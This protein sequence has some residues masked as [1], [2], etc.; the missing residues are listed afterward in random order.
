MK[1]KEKIELYR[2]IEPK[3]KENYINGIEPTKEDFEKYGLSVKDLQEFMDLYLG[4][5]KYYLTMKDELEIEPEDGFKMPPDSAFYNFGIPNL[6][7]KSLKMLLQNR[8]QIII[9]EKATGGVTATWAGGGEIYSFGCGLNDKQIE[10]YIIFEIKNFDDFFRNLEKGNMNEILSVKLFEKRYYNVPPNF[11]IYQAQK[12]IDLYLL[13]SFLKSEPTILIYEDGF[14][15]WFYANLSEYTKNAEEDYDYSNK[16]LTFRVPN[17]KKIY[18]E[19]LSGNIEIL[20][21]IKIIENII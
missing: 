7:L 9:I 16:A 5:W 15:W 3:F 21:E 17:P 11:D 6:D 14:S 2:L 10:D 1:R 8:L 18:S 13:A 20:S 19:L 12:I 4:H